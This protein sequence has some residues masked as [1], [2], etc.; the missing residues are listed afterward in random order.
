MVVF[1]SQCLSLQLFGTFDDKSTLQICLSE[2]ELG[3]NISCSWFLGSLVNNHMFG[4][5]PWPIS[6]KDT[7]TSVILRGGIQDVCFMKLLLDRNKY[8]VRVA[9]VFSTLLNIYNWPKKIFEHIFFVW[10]DNKANSKTS[11]VV[12]YCL[13]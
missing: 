12:K 1:A 8:L 9:D 7:S 4:L 6:S 2:I 10:L 13:I 11:L 5:C 3:I